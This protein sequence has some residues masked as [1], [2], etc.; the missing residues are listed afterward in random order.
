[1]KK[2][3]KSLSLIAAVAAIAIGGTIAYFSDTETSNN[4]VIS[5][6]TIDI[7]VDG[8]NPWS[9]D[10]LYNIAGLEP[11]DE[12]DINVTLEN[13]GTNDVVI[14]KKVSATDDGNLMSEPE[15]LAEGGTY[16]D[17]VCSANSPVDDIS[18]QFVYSMTI[19][20]GTNI[21]QAW[22]VRVSDIND[23]WIP[24]GRLNQGQTV[25][26]D[27][28]YYF[29]ETAGNE[30]QGDSM[31]LDI[32]FY[33]EQLNAPGPAYV[34]GSN[35]VIVDNKNTSSEWEPV[36][37]D[38]TWGILTWD[39]SG[40]FTMKG[41]GL[42]GSSYRGVYYN[43]ST[44]ANIGSGN[45]AVAGGAVTITGTYGSFANADAKYWL[46]DPSGSANAD[47][48]TLWESNLVNN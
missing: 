35:G 19:G 39:G 14:W 13:V 2:I 6:G 28:N 36:V 48:N 22:D 46:R 15:C 12:T 38:G 4:N 45:T 40:N 1:M 8:E 3:L 23:L 27:Q 41:W 30:Y 37:G 21:D 26:V 16:A 18:S 5:A 29:D 44:E 24:V 25:T 33:A 43:G 42:A 17:P 32:T 10:S 31:T 20:G 11:S 47:T 34:A 7:A 9:E